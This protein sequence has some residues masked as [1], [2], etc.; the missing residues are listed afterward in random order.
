LIEKEGRGL[1]GFEREDGV[2]VGEIDSFV[3]E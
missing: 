2:G 1:G 3:A